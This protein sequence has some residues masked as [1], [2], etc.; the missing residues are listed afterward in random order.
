MI[1][2]SLI[3]RQVAVDWAI[4]KDKYIA[5]QEVSSSGN[6]HSIYFL[7]ACERIHYNHSIIQSHYIDKDVVLTSFA[8]FSSDFALTGAVVFDKRLYF[9]GSQKEVTV[10]TE[11]AEP[12][13]KQGS[14]N[15]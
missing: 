4:S 13:N 9:A 5:T 2:S 8:H 3:G 1:Y 15:K 12:N 7:M 6:S 14:K 10:K 11:D